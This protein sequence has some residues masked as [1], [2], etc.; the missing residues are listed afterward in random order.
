MNWR[1]SNQTDTLIHSLIYFPNQKTLLT[2]SELNIYHHL[3][4]PSTGERVVWSLTHSIFVVWMPFIWCLIHNTSLIHIFCELCGSFWIP[5]Y[6]TRTTRR[7]MCKRRQPNWRRTHETAGGLLGLS[8]WMLI[9]YETHHKFTL[10]WINEKFH[11]T[12]SALLVL[13]MIRKSTAI[14]RQGINHQRTHSKIIPTRL[15]AKWRWGCRSSTNPKLFEWNRR[16]YKINRFA[17]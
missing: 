8:N 5:Q 13:H 9:E 1:V 16:R 11:I 4:R 17:E 2:H 3:Q 15:V 7:V 14:R 12:L 6:H 10:K